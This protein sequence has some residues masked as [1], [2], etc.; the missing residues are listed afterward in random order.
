LALD[1]RLTFSVKAPT[2]LT[3]VDSIVFGRTVRA[4]QN[5]H[6]A[7]AHEPFAETVNELAVGGREIVMEAVDR[8]YDDAPL[9]ESSDCAQRVE[10]SFHFDRNP[11]AQLRVILDLLAFT[12]A[13]WRTAC[14]TPL[15]H[16]IVGHDSKRWRR[17]AEIRELRCVSDECDVDVNASDNVITALLCKEGSNQRGV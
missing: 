2:S 17:T 13:G 6:S 4:L 1:R 9:R 14:A 16:A 8:F 5:R 3:I 15:F 7:G 12:S 10:P 11:D